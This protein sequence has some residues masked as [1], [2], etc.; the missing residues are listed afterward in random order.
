MTRL[1]S[2]LFVFTVLSYRAASQTGTTAL[3]HFDPA[4]ATFEYPSS[5]SQYIARFEPDGVASVSAL[6]IELSGPA[7]GSAEVS[8]YGH[9][10]GTSF[11]QLENDLFTP[12]QITKKTN[13][14]ER[15][16]VELPELLQ[17]NNTQFFVVVRKLS[18]GVR[19]MSDSRPAEASCLSNSGGNYYYQFLKSQNGTWSL[20]TRKAFAITAWLDYHNLQNAKWFTDKTAAWGIDTNLS[21]SYMVCEDFNADG[22]PDLFIRGRLFLNQKNQD[23][24]IFFEEHSQKLALSGLP[25]MALAVHRGRKF[26]DLFY[27]MRNEP[28]FR[29]E[30]NEE[31]KYYERF[32]MNGVDAF[33]GISSISSADLNHDGVPDFFVGQLWGAYP[34]PFPNFVLL[35][36]GLRWEDQSTLLYPKHNG[37]ANYPDAIVCRAS[38]QNTWRSGANTNRRSRGS[39]FCDFDNDGD[40][41]LY[42]TNYFLEE[43]EFYENLGNG[44]FR[45]IIKEKDIDQ[46]STGH[47]HGTGVSW[48]DYDA[49]GDMDLLLPQFAHPAF[50]KQYD[51]RSTTVY[52]NTGAPEFKFTDTKE[53][54]GIDFEETYAGGTWGDINNDGLLD[55]IETVYYGCR[56]LKMFIQTQPGQFRLVSHE[57]GLNKINSGEDAIWADLDGDGRQDLIAGSEG[58]IRIFKNQMP[59]DNHWAQFQF[60]SKD[61]LVNSDIRVIAKAGSLKSMRQLYPG[62]GIRMQAP[63]IVHFGLGKQL[64]IEELEVLWPNGE[65]ESWY[66]LPSGQLHQ[67]TQGS[68]KSHTSKGSLQLTVHGNPAGK[69]LKLSI[70]S[71]AG[72]PVEIKLNSLSGQCIYSGS[73]EM[74]QGTQYMVIPTNGMGQGMYFLEIRQGSQFTV[75]KLV[76]G[77]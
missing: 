75:K 73:T 43:D 20:G 33:P 9:E 8:M 53:T 27:F 65:V 59:S 17:F 68:G 67:I 62:Q 31:K 39:Q 19:L 77:D 22:R 32:S 2:L 10:G 36:N 12:L 49:D 60:K 3:R 72:E 66:F 48:A 7:G 54:N 76:L 30:Y 56:Y 28:G 61:G 42:V 51:H 41:D 74:P 4:S 46:N 6:T 50:T 71:K 69:A 11:P 24:E 44:T 47:N 64:E 14:I 29:W 23:G 52:R 38:D 25:T 1:I 58:K 21:N 45:S 5:F 37:S 35:S 34:E 18:S 57:A 16:R 13:G 63:G 55:F 15:I 40:A 26:A 70:Q